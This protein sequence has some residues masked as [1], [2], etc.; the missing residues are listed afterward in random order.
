MQAK[1]GVGHGLAADARPAGGGGPSGPPSPA[2]HAFKRAHEHRY[3]PCGG[4]DGEGFE[5][6][7]RRQQ[8]AKP[9]PALIMQIL[10]ERSS[11]L[12]KRAAHSAVSKVLRRCL[13]T[14]TVFNKCDGPAAALGE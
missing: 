10:L 4:G 7:A 11:G 14:P 13:I 3:R 6:R 2:P 12:W 8:G 9:A 1:P 5:K